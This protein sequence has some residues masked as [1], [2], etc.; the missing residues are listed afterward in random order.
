LIAARVL[1]HHGSAMPLA[2][3]EATDRD[4]ERIHE[5]HVASVRGL[6]GAA[7]EPKVIDGWL[8]GRSAAGYTRGIGDGAMLVAELDAVVVGFCHAMQDEIIA[9]FV[10]PAS[11]GQGVGAALLSTGLERAARSGRAVRLESTLNAVAF[12]ERFG[13]RALGR[14]TVRRNDVDIPV[15]LMERRAG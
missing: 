5:V 3:R 6:C 2:I 12:Y 4:A 9:L 13:F 1:I 11:A 14:S 8:R 15:V 10:H 7:Y